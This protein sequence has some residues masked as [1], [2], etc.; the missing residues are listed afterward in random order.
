MATTNTTNG[1]QLLQSTLYLRTFYFGTVSQT[2]TVAISK[3]GA[4]FA[5]PSISA[6]ATEVGG[7][8]NGRGFYSIQLSVPDTGT[9]GDLAYSCTASSGGPATWTDQ[10]TSQMYG[11]T[12]IGVPQLALNSQNQ[13]LVS[14][15]L[16]QAQNFT[17][18]FFM[19][20]VST[21]NPAPGLSVTGQR[22]FGS[23]FTGVTG[24][25]AEITGVGL[26]GGWYV[27]NGT[28]ADS[29]NAVAGFKFS[30]PGANDTDFSLWFQP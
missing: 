19:T 1:I 25:I 8:G 18:L 11:A 27:F 22:T 15:N 5:A 7:A 20:Q 26:G 12:A 23:A 24:S 21:T 30:S 28:A 14:S 9:L 17:A 10:V 29:A 6:T 16:K 3:N 13:V 4:A 2:V